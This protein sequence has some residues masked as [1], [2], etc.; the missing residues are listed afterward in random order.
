VNRSYRKALNG[1]ALPS[2]AQ[3]LLV[4]VSWDRTRCHDLDPLN[5]RPLYNFASLNAL[6]VQT[7]RALHADLGCASWP[8]VASGAVTD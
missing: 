5:P 2:A 4:R 8:L 6:D 1:V 3:P 7:N